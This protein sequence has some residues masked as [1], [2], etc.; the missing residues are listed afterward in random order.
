MLNISIVFPLNNRKLATCFKFHIV[1]SATIL[2]RTQSNDKIAPLSYRLSGVMAEIDLQIFSLNCN[3]LNDDVKR[4]AVFSKFKRSA[5]GIYLLQETNCTLKI[6]QRWQHEW[7]NKAMYFSHCCC[8]SAYAQIVWVAHSWV[9]SSCCLDGF[10]SRFSTLIISS[11]ISLSLP[12]SSLN[13]S[14]YFNSVT[15][16]PTFWQMWRICP[17]VSPVS[18]QNLQAKFGPLDF[19]WFVFTDSIEALVLIIALHC[20]LVRLFM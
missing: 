14:S 19:L 7:G 10:F 9:R 3:E 16:F 1:G 17:W 2:S 5:A 12:A 18:E 13:I 15:L 6:E 8:C 4:N 11:E 20:F